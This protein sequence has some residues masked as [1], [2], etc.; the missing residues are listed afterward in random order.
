MCGISGIINFEKKP[1]LQVAS[2]MSKK[3][4][5]RDQTLRQH[6]QMIVV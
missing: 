5:H 2:A 4:S 3:I 1:S 6:G